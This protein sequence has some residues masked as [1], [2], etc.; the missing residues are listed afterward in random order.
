MMATGQE[1]VEG[2]QAPLL[3]VGSETCNLR[4]QKIPLPWINV[5]S[6][7]EEWTPN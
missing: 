2:A 6:I 3:L 1:V 5:S 4:Y 7:L